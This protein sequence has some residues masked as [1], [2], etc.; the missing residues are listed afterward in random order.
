MKK[1][2][3]FFCITILLI[4]SLADAS[5]SIKMKPKKMTTEAIDAVWEKTHYVM[6]LLPSEEKTQKYGKDEMTGEL[7][8][9]QGITDNVAVQ[10][11]TMTTPVIMGSSVGIHI[12]ANHEEIAMPIKIGKQL[13]DYSPKLISGEIVIH[14]YNLEKKYFYL[15][16]NPS[17]SSYS[18]EVK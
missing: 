2:F 18:T 9:F 16:I 14:V 11:S 1:I 12:L 17:G 10:I 15:V 3:L 4:L 13:Y 8:F 6:N 5:G 7:Y